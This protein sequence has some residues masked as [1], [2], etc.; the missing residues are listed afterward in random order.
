MSAATRSICGYP[1]RLF[2]YVIAVIA[3]GLP[4]IAGAAASLALGGTPD[5]EKAIGMVVFFA[6]AL[7]AELRPISLDVAGKRV[8]SLAFIFIVSV[9]ILFGWEAGVAVG[10]LAMFGSQLADRP[11]P[12]KVAFNCSV[13]AIAALA[14]AS[15]DFGHLVG[16]EGT[17]T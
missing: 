12:I 10:A 2:G 14:A 15:I 9:Q 11:G 6:C 3:I 8:V 5:A 1:P 17:S 13:Y 4:I 7:G 16:L